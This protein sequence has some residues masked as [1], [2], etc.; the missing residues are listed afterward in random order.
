[1]LRIGSCWF[2]VVSVV[3]GLQWFPRWCLH[4][5]INLS[6]CYLT[7]HQIP[8]QWRMNSWHLKRNPNSAGSCWVPIFFCGISVRF[9]PEMDPAKMLTQLTTNNFPQGVQ[10]HQ[11]VRCLSGEWLILNN[12]AID[13]GNHMQSSLT[14]HHEPSFCTINHHQ[15]W[16]Q[17][18]L[19]I[20]YHHEPRAATCFPM[21]QPLQHAR[22]CKG[23]PLT[24][25]GGQKRCDL[26]PKRTW[27]DSYWS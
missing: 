4:P 16:H 3:V 27:D 14:I 10:V 19:T 17:L 6:L 12:L 22:Q 9:C 13:D 15:T 1:M 23:P 20:T 24:L 21:A 2:V 26:N 8:R 25:E 18:S 11:F 7:V 5:V